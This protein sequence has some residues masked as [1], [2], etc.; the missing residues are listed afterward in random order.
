MCLFH[1][2]IISFGDLSK[3]QT[4]FGENYM[5]RNL[6]L[7]IPT[8]LNMNLNLFSNINHFFCVNYVIL[9][10]LNSFMTEAVII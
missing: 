5:I 7:Q 3:T 8:N 1:A 2:L 10:T 9:G 6:S 4:S